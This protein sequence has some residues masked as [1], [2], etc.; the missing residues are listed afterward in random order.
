MSRRLTAV[1]ATIAAGAALAAVLA[2]GVSTASATTSASTILK[3]FDAGDI[4]SDQVMFNPNAMS[5]AQ[6]QSFLNAKVP[7]CE[8]VKYATGLPC[9]KDY[10]QTT[11][12]RPADPMCHAYTG[13]TNE[14][15]AAI[16]VKVGKACDVNPQVL[17]VLL[18]KE[19]GLVDDTWP[20]ASQYRKATGYGCPDST[21][22]CD[23]TYNGFYN[24]VYKAAWAFQ[25][26]TMPA[27]TGPGTDY[28]SVYSAYPVGK[29]YPILYQDPW[30]NSSCGSK[31]VVV[32]NKATHSLYYYTPYTPNAAALA[33]GFGSGDS[34]S[35][36]GNRNFFLYFTEWFGSTHISV[37]GAIASYWTSHGGANGAL[38]AATANAVNTAAHGGG[39]YQRFEHG[40][41][42]TSTAGTFSVSGALLTEY[43]AQR[44][45][46]GI[47]GWPLSDATRVTANGG[48]SMQRFE[49]GD[50]YSSASGSFSLL[51][52]I[53]TTYAAQGGV[54]GS[55][56][57]PSS[58]AT[59]VATGQV[60][61]FAGGSVYFNAATGGFAV[62]KAV[63]SGYAKRQGP[64]GFL[65]W[66]VASARSRTAA[67]RTG[68][69]ESFQQ[70]DL[71]VSSAGTG[72]VLTSIRTSLE[73]GPAAGTNDVDALG[74]PTADATT[75]TVNGGGTVQP[76]TGG[77][78]YV[79][80]GK[81]GVVVTGRLLS[82]YRSAGEAAS[83]LGW[84]TG[85][86]SNRT[87]SGLTMRVQAFS[88]GSAYQNGSTI[89]MVTGSIYSK[90]VERGGPAGGL[91]WVTGDQSTSSAGG[92][93][94]SQAFRGG[95]VYAAAGNE[96][97]VSGRM[98]SF[99]RSI[100]EAS[101]GL[102]WPTDGAA[103]QTIAG[104]TVRVQPFSTGAAYQT[105][106]T[107]RTVTGGIYARYAERGGPGGD[108]G[109]VTGD[110]RYSSAAGGGWSQA[111]TKGTM[112]FGAAQQKGIVL[113]GR[114][115]SFYQGIG[116]A[117]SALGWPTGPAANR[118]LSGLTVRV[119]DFSNGSA[120]QTGSTVRTVTGGIHAAY[121]AAG[122]PA[123]ALGWVTGNAVS[124]TAN[125][126]GV[127][128]T[129]AHGTMFYSTTTR[130]AA[131][132]S[133]AYLS[134]YTAQGGTGGTLG[135]PGP[136]QTVTAATPGTMIVF[137]NG[138]IYSSAVGTNEVK[139]GIRTAYLAHQGPAGPLGWPL[140]GEVP[141]GQTKVQRFQHGTI[142][143]VGG[144]AVVAVK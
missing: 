116:E 141:V 78:L 119:Q 89:R 83:P 34:C 9:L 51:G 49:A 91:G 76:F 11:Q 69:V 75:T 90:Y 48:G 92:G 63:D 120:Y 94:S 103:N 25:R 68:S 24:Q 112:Y 143:W 7:V 102:G 59:T 95:T 128:Q 118:T 5:Q 101:S 127:S 8:N 67:G 110:Q 131:P 108:L 45:V 18:Q 126:G 35:A 2:G 137:T 133:G 124:T 113:S 144:K 61:H 72:A 74:W 88:A 52:D 77:R 93:G 80:T 140:T 105:G 142:T 96:A 28:Y 130:Q 3:G 85:G 135:W 17:L 64:S 31:S 138:R 21:A 39:T 4:I 84:P 121:E 111:F 123:G 15:A 38:G 81:L 50:V 19:Q 36:Y 27:G 13:A 98:L 62:P 54:T 60:Q 134:V 47:M 73:A 109:W 86:A 22:V 56:G 40:M 1:A 66:P 53:R 58:S 6:V 44:G 107:V 122:G 139:G 55:L 87:L 115:L 82:F 12:S 20:T 136:L 79:P 114:M 104:R 14:T 29:A 106:S 37:S 57:F 16:I 23:A 70:G 117:S 132:L 42:F 41:I 65:G 71:Y 100:G 125:H 99:Y 43:S 32:K 33:A 46:G 10:T 30:S 129:F 26:Y 97:V